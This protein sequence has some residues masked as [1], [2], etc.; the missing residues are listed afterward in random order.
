MFR[1]QRSGGGGGK[2]CRLAFALAE[3]ARTSCA[4]N[5]D[6]S[7]AF[8][9][10]QVDSGSV[11]A[12][13]SPA[14]PNSTRTKLEVVASRSDSPHGINRVSHFLSTTVCGRRPPCWLAT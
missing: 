10:T 5:L 8:E 9:G 6:R 4:G 14:S 13:G 12:A 11:L 7:T 2:L 3:E 1:C